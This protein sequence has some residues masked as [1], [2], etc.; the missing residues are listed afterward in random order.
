MPCY[1]DAMVKDFKTYCEWVS[2]GQDPRW[3]QVAVVLP[4]SKKE[5]VI[6]CDKLLGPCCNMGRSL[7][8]KVSMSI[9]THFI[10]HMLLP[11]IHFDGCQCHV[12]VQEKAGD[13]AG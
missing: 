3:L 6:A 13:N 9:D 1:S 7:F 11:V 5:G 8:L 10:L 4:E 2:E 12:S